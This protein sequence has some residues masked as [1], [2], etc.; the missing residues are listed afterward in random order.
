MKSLFKPV[1]A[2]SLLLT[3]TASS[4]ALSVEAPQI[5]EPAA[6]TVLQIADNNGNP[7][8]WNRGSQRWD[9]DRDDD[10]DD[11]DDRWD[12]DDDDDDRWG[13]DGDD[14]RWDDDDDDD[15]YGDD[16]DDDD[17]GDDDDD[18][19]DDDDGDDD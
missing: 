9:D 10:R 2:F 18:D 13:D 1:L 17:D 15:D 4:L 12:D 8:W 11:R 7:P 16:D 5:V 19:D 14:D 6:P 3:A